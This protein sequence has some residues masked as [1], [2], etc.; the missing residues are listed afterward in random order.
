M[1]ELSGRNRRLQYEW[2]NLEKRLASRSD[3]EY[4]ITKVNAQ[5]MPIQ[6]QISYHIKSICG[7]TNIENLDKPGIKNH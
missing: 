4:S 6:Y 1:K 7:V 5:G 2:N 3:I